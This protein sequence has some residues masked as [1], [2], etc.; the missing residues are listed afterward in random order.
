[1]DRFQITEEWIAQAYRFELD[2]SS[3]DPA[4]SSHTG[5]KRFSWNY[6][7]DLINEQLRAREQFRIIAI[8]QGAS[9]D[10]AISF[11]EKACAIPYL[12]EMNEKHKKDHEAKIAA[13]K[14]KS[15]EYIPVSEW[16]PWSMES[17][18]YIW[19]RVK[20]EVAP[21]WYGSSKTCSKCKTKKVN[22]SRSARIFCCDN[23]G[24]TID[25]DLNAAKNLQALAELACM[26][27]LAQISTG[28]PVDW[29][30]IP[31]RPFG[32]E[33]DKNTRSSRGCARAGGK[34]TKGG[35]RKTAR[36][37][38]QNE[39]VTAFDREAAKLVEVGG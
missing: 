31:V 9:H 3:I 10:E 19:N 17:M 27:I 11:A 29:S 15:S 22:L 14:R 24:L 35:E 32:W 13:G 1:M 26:C 2:M 16:C 4:I 34:K 28:T 38:L 25:R 39:V 23:C 7:L 30:K 6:M 21:W 36:S 18:R 37:D 12:V 5:A 20:D 8:L 33:P